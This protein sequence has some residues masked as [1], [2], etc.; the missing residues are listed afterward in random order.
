[1]NHTSKLSTIKFVFLAAATLFFII[2]SNAGP[3][4]SHGGKSHGGTDF[5]KFQ[6]VQKAIQL[7]DRLIIAEKLPEVWE[8][9]LDAIM[10]STR[11]SKGTPEYVV[12]FKRRNGDPGSVYFFFDQKG[13][14]AGSNFTGK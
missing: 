7:Y 3:A 11:Q 2:T 14:Y 6:A 10:V 4:L 1:M 9:Q 5:S 13:E 12:Q 8:T